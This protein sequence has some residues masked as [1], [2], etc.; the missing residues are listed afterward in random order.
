M[1]FFKTIEIGGRALNE[2]VARKLEIS[3][4]EARDLRRRVALEAAAAGQPPASPAEPGGTC[5]NGAVRQAVFDATRGLIDELAREVALCLRYHS[6]TFRGHRPA[7]VRLIGG[8]AVDP[9]VLSILGGALPIAVEPFR[10]LYSVDTARMPAAERRGRLS[11]WTVAL[12]LGLKLTRDYFG[13]RDG[14]QRTE[15]APASALASVEAMDAPRGATAAAGDAAPLT[16]GA[17]AAAA[18]AA[19]GAGPRREGAVAHA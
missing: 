9:L 15:P 12:G 1:T 6:V 8:E 17:I 7:K 13:A 3:P 5:A 2:A 14:R 11:E 10:P 18:A 4:D 19:S 16:A